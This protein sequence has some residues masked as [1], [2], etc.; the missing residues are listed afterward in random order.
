MWSQL[1]SVFIAWLL[2]CVIHS[3]MASTS[4]KQVSYQR[5]GLNDR[6]YR[7]AYVLI[8]SLLLLPLVYLIWADSTP[9]V[10]QHQG[11]MKIL[12]D[13]IALIALLGFLIVAR[14]YNMSSFMSLTADNSSPGLSI[15]WLHRYVRHPW[16]FFGLLIIWT[17]DMSALWLLSCLVITVYLI[18]GSKLEENKLISQYGDAYR[19]YQQQVPGLFMIPGRY[20]SDEAML[21]LNT[22]RRS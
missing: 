21:K 1:L 16:Y 2:Y 9:I 10:W 15:S 8:A 11:W 20:M 19:Y 6:S 22:L 14:S 4:F 5:L 12:M 18:V 7:L 17:R 13:G 3:W